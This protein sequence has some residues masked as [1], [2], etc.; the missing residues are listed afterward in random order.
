MVLTSDE[1]AL[2]GSNYRP[3]KMHVVKNKSGRA[4][5]EQPVRVYGASSLVLNGK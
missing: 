4:G 2:V 5:F 1:T 3:A